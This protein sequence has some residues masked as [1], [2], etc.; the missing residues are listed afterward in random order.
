LEHLL[1]LICNLTGIQINRGNVKE[2]GVSLV[3]IGPKSLSMA[4]KNSKSK[5][6]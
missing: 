6:P 2:D 4:L 1:L 5:D 3:N